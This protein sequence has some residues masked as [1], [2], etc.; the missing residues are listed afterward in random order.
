ML[1]DCVCGPG[2]LCEE[3]YTCGCECHEDGNC[4]HFIKDEDDDE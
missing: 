1:V 4:D 2:C 3:G